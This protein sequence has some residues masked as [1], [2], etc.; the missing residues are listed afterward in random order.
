MRPWELQACKKSGPRARAV[1]QRVLRGSF[2]TWSWGLMRLEACIPGS[3]E[4]DQG[5]E[6]LDPSGK[7]EL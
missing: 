7:R 1:E 6:F 5:I 2:E 3:G 4:R